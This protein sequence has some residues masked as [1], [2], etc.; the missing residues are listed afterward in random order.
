MT[1]MKFCRLGDGRTVSYREQGKGPTVVMLHGWGM[2]SVVFQSL[3]QPLSASFRILA[4]DLRGHG[5][6][7]SGSGYQLEHL[8]SDVEE[9]LEIVGSEEICLFGWS[10]GGMVALKLVERLGARV[11]KLVLM[12]TTPCFVQH[13]SWL[14]GQSAAQVKIMAR[15][16]RRDPSKTLDSFFMQQFDGEDVDDEALHAL[17][18]VILD[19]CPAP[20]KDAGLGGLETLLKTDLLGCKWPNVPSLVL[21][22]ECDTVIPPAAGRY[23]AEHLPN[24]HYIQLDQIGHAPL[25][26]Q[27]HHCAVVIKDFLT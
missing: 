23:L 4:P 19:T 3:M 8:A 11:R 17:K 26:S 16:F 14:A 7:D 25:I 9:W 12:S 2:S 24:A 10:L 6:S 22:G 15:Q 18:G 20:G 5:R 13:D 27:P 1:I 21:H